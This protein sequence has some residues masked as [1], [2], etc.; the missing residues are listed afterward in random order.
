MIIFYVFLVVERFSCSFG[1]VRLL[2]C[3]AETEASS[4]RGNWLSGGHFCGGAGGRETMLTE[5]IVVWIGESTSNK[6]FVGSEW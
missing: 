2:L 5:Q 3:P 6:S 4:R 1:R